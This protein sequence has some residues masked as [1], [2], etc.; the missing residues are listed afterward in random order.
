MYVFASLLPYLYALVTLPF[1]MVAKSL[2]KGR[3]FIIYCTLSVMG[4]IY[5][6]FALFDTGSNAMFWG[7]LMMMLTIPLYALVAAS[8][9]KKGD[10][11]LYLDDN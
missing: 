7:V 8:R 10:N 6:L 9:C 3:Q 4:I 2:N 11:I 1:I 5:I